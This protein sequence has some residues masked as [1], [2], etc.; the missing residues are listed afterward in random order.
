MSEAPWKVAERRIAEVIGGRR[1]PVS[2]RARG[3]VPDIHHAWLCPEVKSR[4]TLPAWLIE[5]LAQAR[6]AAGPHQ[7]PV[8]VLHETG[9]RYGHALV[10]VRLDDW[11]DWFGDG[12]GPVVND[13]GGTEDAPED[14]TNL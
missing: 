3:D 1:V 5:A 8:A 2:G 12:A 9:H 6:A 10:V 11:L 4:R 7:L 14:V 13:A